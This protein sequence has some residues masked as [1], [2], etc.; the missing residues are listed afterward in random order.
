LKLYPEDAEVNSGALFGLAET[1]E[2]L[3][4]A[5]ESKETYRELVDLYGQSNQRTIRERVEVAR[6]RYRSV[7]V[8]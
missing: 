4:K 1:L 2:K 5:E 8:R 6:L 7:S 3:G